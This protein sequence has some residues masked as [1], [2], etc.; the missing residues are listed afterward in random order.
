M[1]IVSITRAYIRTYG[2]NDQ[3]TAYVEWR[4]EHGR[5]CRTEGDAEACPVLGWRPAGEHMQALF[6]RAE[7][8]GVSVEREVW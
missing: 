5:T 6:A 7:R 4:D 3:T 8:E 2:D 1:K